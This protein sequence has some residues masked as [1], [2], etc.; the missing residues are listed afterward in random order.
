M[1]YD[2]DE[3]FD[4]ELDDSLLEPRYHGQWKDELSGFGKGLLMG[5]YTP[6]LSI[7]GGSEWLKSSLKSHGYHRTDKENAYLDGRSA[8]QLL[9]T[10]VTAGALTVAYFTDSDVFT[11]E[12]LVASLSATNTIDLLVNAAL[13]L[14]K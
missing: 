13:K 10:V 3:P 2:E 4:W 7:T 9:S 5:L 8:G 14:T 11:A 12:A 1:C 6:F